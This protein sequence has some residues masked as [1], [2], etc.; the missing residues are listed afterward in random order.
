ME[1][2]AYVNTTGGQYITLWSRNK[3]GQCITKPEPSKHVRPDIPMVSAQGRI[4]I[5][6][7]RP[8]EPEAVSCTVIIVLLVGVFQGNKLDESP[9]TWGGHRAGEW[10]SAPAFPLIW[11]CLGLSLTKGLWQ[12]RLLLSVWCSLV[13]LYWRDW[14]S[15]LPTLEAD[16]VCWGSD[17]GW[18]EVKSSAQFVCL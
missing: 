16:Q 6:P 18:D 3:D 8:N 15:F 9:V 4:Y 1:T 17:G 11:K 2:A 12:Y 13:C 5:C 14:T 7:S 10:K